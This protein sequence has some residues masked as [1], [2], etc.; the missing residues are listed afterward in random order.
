MS[1][2]DLDQLRA[3]WT[4]QDRRIDDSL[5]MDVEAMRA[6]LLRRAASAFV[7]HRRRRTLGLLVGGGYLAA[8]LAFIALHW[9]QWNWVAAAAAQVPLLL[10][11]ILIDLRERSAL[12]RLDLSAP[13]V[14]VR[15]VLDRLRWR[16]LRLV[17]GYLALS[18]LLW[19]PFVLVLLKALFG[20][21]L[22]N[23]LPPGVVLA[24][25]VAGVAFIPVALAVSWVLTRAFGRSQG[26]QRFM[27]DSA[28]MSWRHA[29]DAFAER[30]AFEA[31]LDDGTL[32]DLSCLQ[33]LPAHLVAEV[34]AL[35]R[36]LL[37]GIL[38]CAAVVLMF[39]LFN[40]AHGGQAHL[41]VPSIVL[42]WGT[43][44]HMIVQ[45]LNRQ[46]LTRLASDEKSLRD[47]LLAALALRRRVALATIGMAPVAALL[48]A[49]V[50]AK[51]VFATDLANALPRE[52]L[53]A[54]GVF[55]LAASGLSWRRILREPCGV[56]PRLINLVCLGFVGRAQALIDTLTSAR[57][58]R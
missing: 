19:W 16:R 58:G 17:K 29:S 47:R 25:L 42:L 44:A 20:A 43:L 27:D 9:G 28:G 26:W 39:G 21:D 55:A 7:W 56:P 12:R 52:A 23:G 2:P 24:N 5:V 35:R 48:L 33:P 40:A 34:H 4:Q 11:E 31:A 36:H 41:L 8:L 49:V 46:A 15:A 30:E 38:G 37:V 22:L 32:E 45:I 50:V 6:M 1:F 13:V 18:L 3:K 53:L 54:L 10:A 14:H 51:A 57:H